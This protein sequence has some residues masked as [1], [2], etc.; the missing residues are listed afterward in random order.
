M[1][2]TRSMAGALGATEHTSPTDKRAYPTARNTQGRLQLLHPATLDRYIQD[3]TYG[4]DEVRDEDS[5]D[6]W[7]TRTSGAATGSRS[8]RTWGRIVVPYSRCPQL[9]PM[10]RLARG[11]LVFV[12]YAAEDIPNGHLLCVQTAGHW[13][14]PRPQPWSIDSS[15]RLLP[16]APRGIDPRP[17]TLHRSGRCQPMEEA[18]LVPQTYPCGYVDSPRAPW[19]GDGLGPHV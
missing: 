3:R 6:M 8:P 18:I 10:V 19:I 1:V 4:T 13:L 5:G 7:R 11:I 2:L 17:S 15:S 9:Y 16:L 14:S 12:L